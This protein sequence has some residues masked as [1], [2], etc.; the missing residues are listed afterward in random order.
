[1]SAL[2]SLKE[3]AEQ[4]LAAAVDEIFEYFEKTVTDYD[5]ELDRYCKLLDIILQPEIRLRRADVRSLTVSAEVP[6]EQQEMKP[7]LDQEAPEPPCIKEEQEEVWSSQEGEQLQGLEEADITLISVKS[8]DDEEKPELS[9][10]HQSQIEEHREAEAPASCP[11]EQ[12]KAEV[13]GE[14]CGGSEPACDV[15][16]ATADSS[17]DSSEPKTED[18]DDLNRFNGG[19]MHKPFNCLFCEKRF[20]CKLD[21]VIHARGHTGEKPFRCSD[22]GERFSHRAALKQHTMLH[23]GEKPVTGSVCDRRIIRKSQI[24][25]QECVDQSSCRK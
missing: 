11:A 1:M 19:K 10:F 18:R 5:E 6:P 7:S 23:T 2:E 14:D 4:R 17:V 20:V 3:F 16:A 21:L 24:K 25:T 12:M 9:Q 22:C 8:E 15:L 13:D